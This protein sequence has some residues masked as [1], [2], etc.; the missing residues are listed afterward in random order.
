MQLTLPEAKL[1][2]VLSEIFGTDNVIPKMRVSALF[3]E[4]R[5]KSLE[6]EL[7][8]G[9]LERNFCLFTILNTDD[10]PRLVVEFYNGFSSSIDPLEEEHQRILPG[11][12]GAV[13]VSYVT[14]S[15]EEF[16]EALS[17]DSEIKVPD[18]IRLRYQ[19]LCGE[20]YE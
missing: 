14:I 17:P 11:L 1:F 7:A 2:R 16:E 3:P 8:E 19:E 4:G 18:L 6:F 9:W 12:L 20:E 15:N 10:S 13:G 5:P